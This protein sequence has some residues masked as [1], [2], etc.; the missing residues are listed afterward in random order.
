VTSD[1]SDTAT[2]DTLTT[3]AAPGSSDAT[4]NATT[5]SSSDAGS[6][7]DLG[8]GTTVQGPL[9]FSAV[10]DY[11]AADLAHDTTILIGDGTQSG[12]FGIR[13]VTSGHS[14]LIRRGSG[15]FARYALSVVG[16]LKV[17][18]VFGFSGS[19]DES[20]A[21]ALLRFNS[22]GQDESTTTNDSTLTGLQFVQISANGLVLVVDGQTLV[23]DSATIQ[24]S[25]TSTDAAALS[26]NL[27][28]VGFSLD[29]NA[30]RLVT[31]SGADGTVLLTSSG[32]VAALAGA[33]QVQTAPGS[34]RT[35]DG[36]ITFNTTGAAANGRVL[37]AVTM[38]SGPK[39]GAAAILTVPAKSSVQVMSCKQWCEIVYNGK[40]GWVYKSYVKTGA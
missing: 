4:A 10:D 25:Q 8:S 12:V 23:S 29:D 3:N 1:G 6:S 22:T 32:A 18:G 38:R 36:Q 31:V 5:D 27:H 19:T 28:G 24:R 9:S 34:A 21:S 39:K 14:K 2:A 15:D 17:L 11:Y 13:F 37:R 7:L 26:A 30:T 33:A 16:A 20:T 40:H 35:F